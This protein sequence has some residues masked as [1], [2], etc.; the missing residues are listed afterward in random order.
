MLVANNETIY[1]R[2]TIDASDNKMLSMIKRSVLEF[3]NR[4]LGNL[5][6]T[7]LPQQ[8]FNLNLPG[9]LLSRDENWS[10]SL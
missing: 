10:P 7:T 9:L 1:S 6:F 3:L 4:G 8:L 5:I 2:E